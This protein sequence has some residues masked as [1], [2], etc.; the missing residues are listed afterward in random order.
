M[1]RGLTQILKAGVPTA[2]LLTSLRMLLRWARFATLA[3]AHASFVPGNAYMDC[4]PAFL[5]GVLVLETGFGDGYY[6]HDKPSV[7]GLWP[8]VGEYGTS[9]CKKPTRSSDDPSRVF[10]C[11]EGTSGPAEHQLQFETHEW[12]KHGSC[13][14]VADAE[15]Y[16]SQ[17]SP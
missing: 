4:G 9:K 12:E 5:C 10:S 7:H 15:D 3:L 13:A 16:F 14:G 11:Y 8:E 17:I 2:G 6:K 1:P